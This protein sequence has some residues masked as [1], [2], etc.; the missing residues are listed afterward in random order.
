MEEKNKNI[1]Y[2]IIAIILGLIVGGC[3][4]VKAATIPAFENLQVYTNGNLNYAYLLP[5]YD[6]TMS[7]DNATY[8]GT[9]NTEVWNNQLDALEQDKVLAIRFCTVPYV[10]GEN[11]T[12]QSVQETAYGRPK[13]VKLYQTTTP[14]DFLHGDGNTYPGYEMEIQYE[15]GVGNGVYA[16]IDL[17][18]G[19]NQIQLYLSTVL[20]SQENGGIIYKIRYHFQPYMKA[21]DDLKAIVGASVENQLEEIING[22]KFEKPSREEILSDYEDKEEELWEIIGVPNYNDLNI[23]I[24]SNTNNKIWNLIV[25]I[26]RQNTAIFTMVIT[27]LSISILKLVLNR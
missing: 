1:I 18:N 5:G 4:Q 17:D 7:I 12:L 9:K 8:T 24:D 23:D 19:M 6:F 13:N 26:L 22:G 14:C 16:Y 2:S 15:I 10:Q 11:I 27:I 3:T 25:Y 21:P 20:R